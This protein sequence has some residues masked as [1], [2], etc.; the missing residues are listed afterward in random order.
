MKQ[1]TI[2]SVGTLKEK[3]L[4]DAAAEYEKRLSAFCR[5]ENI[6]LKEERIANENNA[7]EVAASLAA[8]GERMLARVPQGAYTVALC[9][10][11]KEPD[12]PAL[13]RELG[14]ALDRCGKLCFFIGSSHGLSPAVKAAANARISLS[15]LTFPH[16]L[17]RVLLLEALYRSMNILAGKRYHK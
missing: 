11:G 17:A 13:A 12:S 8:E 16:G 3:F 2:I 9:V 6:H 5:V 10:E 14:E 15:R 4:R 7:A 1:A